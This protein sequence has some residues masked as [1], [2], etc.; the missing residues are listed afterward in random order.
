MI[1]GPGRLR[2]GRGGGKSHA[3]KTDYQCKSK[4]KMGV[5]GGRKDL[6]GTVRGH[7]SRLEKKKG[8]PQGP[9]GRGSDKKR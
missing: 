7:L 5:G 3:L 1:T 2:G 6:S 4:R 9:L 8:V